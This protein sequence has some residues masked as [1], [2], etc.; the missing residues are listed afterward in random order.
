[1]VAQLS[2]CR[3][4]AVR[5]GS[6]FVPARAE[7]N[8]ECAVAYLAGDSAMRHVLDRAEHA[9]A[10]LHLRVNTHDDDSF[11]PNTRTVNWDPYS[12][13]RTTSGGTQ[14]P[15]LGLGH[16]LAHAAVSDRTRDRGSAIALRG[17]DDAEERR[18]IRGAEAH[19]AQTLGEA[20]RHDHRGT[21]YRVASPLER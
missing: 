20:T 8:F 16:E 14:S 2:H 17:Y 1:M 19:A 13:L 3:A 7:R 21:C 11:D 18:V 6:L 10:A 9:R 12:A 4:G 5:H 15:A